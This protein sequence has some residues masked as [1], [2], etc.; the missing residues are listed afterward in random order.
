M[1][2]DNDEIFKI[3]NEEIKEE[4]NSIESLEEDAVA[5]TIHIKPL[6]DTRGSVVGT[7]PSCASVCAS[8]FSKA[9]LHHIFEEDFH[10]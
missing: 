7:R 1:I 9:N 5:P 10:W 3:R 2:R 4:E 6:C 8:P